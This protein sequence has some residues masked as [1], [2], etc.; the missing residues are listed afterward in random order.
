M[1]DAIL[2]SERESEGR[3]G[4]SNEFSSQ[5]D[6]SAGGSRFWFIWPHLL[7]KECVGYDEGGRVRTTGWIER[8]IEV[9]H[10]AHS[11]ATLPCCF[12]QLRYLPRAGQWCHH[13]LCIKWW[14]C[15][16]ARGIPWT[17]VCTI[18]A[19]AVITRSS[20][21]VS[22]TACQFSF[23]RFPFCQFEVSPNTYYYF[24]GITIC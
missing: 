4:K 3:G 19:I 18:T 23:L 9:Y 6:C 12:S 16:P 2:H 1:L 24:L 13:N 14:P 10:A 8:F 20:N 15:C 21:H 17:A 5:L 7:A 22:H 11:A